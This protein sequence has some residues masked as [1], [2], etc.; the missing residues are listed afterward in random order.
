MASYIHQRRDWPSFRWD[1]RSLEGRLGAVRHLQGRLIGRMEGLGFRLGAEASLQGLTEEVVTSSAIEGEPLDRAQVRSSIARRLG[2]DIGGLT[3]A[4]R[5]VEGAVEMLLDATQ[6][7]ARPLTK[8][9]LLGWQAALFPPA[10]A[11]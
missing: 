8:A 9:R 5:A 7:Y 11:A 10:A 3:P 6:R 2:I 4:D 1:R